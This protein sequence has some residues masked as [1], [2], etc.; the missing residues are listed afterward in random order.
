MIEVAPGKRAVAVITPKFVYRI[1]GDAQD[2]N[3]IPAET[4]K[5]IDDFAAPKGYRS[6]RAREARLCT[7]GIYVTPSRWFCSRLSPSIRKKYRPWCFVKKNVS[8]FWMDVR[9]SKRA[10]STSRLCRR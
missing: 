5:A 1:N 7:L 2:V 9:S 3:D 10:A 8:R 6:K 4:A